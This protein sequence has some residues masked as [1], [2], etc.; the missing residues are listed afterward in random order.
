M[1]S[2][3]DPGRSHLDVSVRDRVATVRLNRPKVLN[4]LDSDTHRALQRVFD[5]LE[6][7]DDVGAVLLCG[8]GTSFCSGSDLREIGDLVGVAAQ[9]YVRLDFVT[10]N[11]LA[12][13]SKPVVAAIHGW[14]VGGGV[15]LALACDI[16]IAAEDAVFS[17]REVALGSVP[18]SGGLQRLPAVV[19]VG[20]AKDWIL[21]GRDV[22][23]PD[24]ERRGL[25]TELVPADRL[26]ARGH[27]LA[28][29][30]AGRN[31][32]ALHLAKVAL[33]PRPEAD[34]GLVAAFQMLAGDACHG[35][36]MYLRATRAYTDKRRS[37][38]GQNG[39]TRGEA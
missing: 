26:A 34:H 31:P 23:A 24:A 8:A 33:D 15:E 38:A 27:E 2:E 5:E 39:P 19:G 29:E 10:K 35:D 14:C 12:G 22:S 21:T 18:G 37:G 36:P 4:A 7:R 6:L 1:S 32:T 9:R 28:A 11:R 20:V 13:M 30:L 17:M 25:V 16:R 3:D